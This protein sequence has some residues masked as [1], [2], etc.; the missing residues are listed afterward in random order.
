MNVVFKFSCKS[1][2]MVYGKL[3]IFS[4]ILAPFSVL[5]RAKANSKNIAIGIKNNWYHCNSQV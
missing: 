4:K 1:L 5:F 3:S 2:I